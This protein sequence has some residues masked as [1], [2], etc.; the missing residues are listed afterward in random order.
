[1]KKKELSIFAYIKEHINEDGVYNG[2]SLMDDPAPTLHRL[3]GADDAY[4]YTADVAPDEAA[5]EVIANVLLSYGNEPSP[6]AKEL[7]EKTIVNTP[8]ISV[9]DPLVDLLSSEEM[10]KKLTQL[11]EDW[12]Y[13]AHNRELVKYAIIILAVDG[14]EKLRNDESKN[15]WK[16][17]VDLARCEEFTFFLTYA[18]HINNI[19]PQEELWELARCTKGWGHLFSLR[20]LECKN[21]DAELWILQHGSEIEIDYPPV[22][23]VVMRKGHIMR[24][25]SKEHLDYET[26][27][28][29]L[30]TV[31]NY[32]M[33]LSRYHIG[34]NEQGKIDIS[35]IDTFKLISETLRHAENY[36]STANELIGI[37]HL[38]AL[39]K[40][41]LNEDNWT[42]LTANTTNEL[43]GLCDKLIFALDWN[44]IIEHELF[45]ED[46][47]VDYIITEFAFELGIDIWDKLFEHLQQ[48]PLKSD[49]FPYLLSTATDEQ[50][51]KVLTF[52]E[53]NLAL[54]SQS[55]TALLTPLRYLETHPGMGIPIVKASL[56][57]IY[58]WPRGAATVTLENWGREYLTPSIQ[59]ALLTARRLCQYPFITIRIDALLENTPYKP[60]NQSDNSN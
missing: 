14:L 18:Y 32:V 43:I 28:G 23:L 35:G 49:I 1:M 37:L 21:E 12:F 7:V 39:L 41:L 48:Q 30:M 16:D 47:S 29:C 57:S 24:H 36:A 50:I 5:A 11:A 40:R 54:Y 9:C 15:L 8:C 46:G 4:I 52:V 2:G 58:D 19:K 17:L 34:N 25:L 55:E 44:N 10:P 60:N 13:T 56:T 6:A 53:E 42:A 38:S 20:Y 3:A 22:S 51:K 26:Y 33:M 45:Q 31:S 27:R 59:A